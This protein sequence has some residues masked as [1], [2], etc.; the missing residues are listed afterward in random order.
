MHAKIMRAETESLTN[1]KM[2]LPAVLIF[3]FWGVG[4]GGGEGEQFEILM[5]VLRRLLS[6]A[7]TAT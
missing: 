5:A 6:L 7:Y 3:F 2:L 1:D 4:V